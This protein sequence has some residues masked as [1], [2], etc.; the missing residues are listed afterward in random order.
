MT[1]R[2]GECMTSSGRRILALRKAR[3]SRR[4]PVPGDSIFR[5]STF[6]GSIFPG[7]SGTHSEPDPEGHPKPISRISFPNSS[8]TALRAAAWILQ[9]R[10]EEEMS[11]SR[12]TWDSGNRFE[13]RMP[14]LMC[15]EVK[16]ARLVTA[17]ARAGAGRRC[18]VR[19]A[20]AQAASTPYGGAHGSRQPVPSV[21]VQG[22]FLRFV[23][24]AMDR[25]T[26][27]GLFR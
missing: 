24:P 15:P 4:L 16:C 6:R 1:P 5:I 9:G 2:S 10:Y 17:L 21:E 19:S 27:R 14:G 22:S 18:P 20:T 3:G 23:E 12:S 26:P 25:D 13:A 7:G 8:G 11:N